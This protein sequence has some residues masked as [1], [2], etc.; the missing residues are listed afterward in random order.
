MGWAGIVAWVVWLTAWLGPVAGL[1]G[2][3]GRALQV[4][5]QEARP[6]VDEL[7][8]RYSQAP[9]Q[10]VPGRTADPKPDAPLVKGATASEE[11]EDD[12]DDPEEAA[13]DA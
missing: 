7:V 10:V 13:A 11:A 1:L 5:D 6:H 9:S 12:D 4:L 2:A 3:C 8:R